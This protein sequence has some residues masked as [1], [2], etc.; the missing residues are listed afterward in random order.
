A[1][2]ISCRLSLVSCTYLTLS[3]CLTPSLHD[4]LPI[5]LHG[6][7]PRRRAAKDH[8]PLHRGEFLSFIN[9][10]VTISPRVVGASPLRSRAMVHRLLTA[11]QS[12]RVDNVM[13]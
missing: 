3:A 5:S 10:H 11:S 9:D 7:P 2:I 4:A 6:H 8:T 1:T 13:R 12:L